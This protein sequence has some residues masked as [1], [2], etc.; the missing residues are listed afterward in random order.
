MTW[1]NKRGHIVNMYKGLKV[2]EEIQNH[3]LLTLNV[4]KII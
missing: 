3:V 4:T 2:G 1:K